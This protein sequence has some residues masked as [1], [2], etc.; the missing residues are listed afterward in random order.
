MKL[1]TLKDGSRDG[2]LA[3]VSRDLSLAVT[4]RT[5]A[6]TLQ[7]A[8]ERWNEVEEPLAAMYEA[9]NRGALED[10]SPFDPRSAH[11]PLPRAYQW[12]DG[13]VFASHGERM[14][15]ALHPDRPLAADTTPRVYQ[16]ASD[17]FIGA[18]DDL[19]VADEADGID[20]E[21][22]I[23]V[24]VDDVAMRTPALAAERH[25]KLL[26]LVNDVSLRAYVAA[27]ISGGFGFIR[28][29]PSSSFAP[30]AVTPDEVGEAWQGGRLHLP[31]RIRWNDEW[32]GHPNAGA[33]TFDFH[34]IIEHVT[35]TRRLRAG[36]II[37]SGTVSNWE[38][39]VGC[40]C[41]TEQRAIEIVELGKPTTPFMKIGDRV[42]IEVLGSDG[43]SIFGAIDQQ[44]VPL[45]PEPR[46]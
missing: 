4:A 8:I 33:M 36:T 40:A 16:G 6:V 43:R 27:E 10:A 31:L 28:A 46:A 42:R 11:A 20:F 24:V 38:R 12:L 45:R 3:V 25:V 30:V 9:L 1:A 14:E 17:D 13:S 29:K 41:I 23:A 37:G 26:L 22:E 32:F 18:C 35:R 39:D 21:G 5:V 34:Q 7:A 2:V 44:I 19:V 15:R